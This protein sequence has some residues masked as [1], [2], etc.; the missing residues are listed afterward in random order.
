MVSHIVKQ[1]S[2]G[3]AC[4]TVRYKYW[5]GLELDDVAP[6]RGSG[7]PSEN[8]TPCPECAEAKAAD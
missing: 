7:V 6:P 4:G 5:C 2:K 3:S 1:E 8:V